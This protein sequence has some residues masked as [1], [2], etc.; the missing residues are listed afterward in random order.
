LVQFPVAI[1]SPNISV[2]NDELCGQA[3]HS[4]LSKM[5]ASRLHAAA[6]IV[7]FN[8]ATGF[9]SLTMTGSSLSCLSLA[10]VASSSAW[11]SWMVRVLSAFQNGFAAVHQCQ[12]LVECERDQPSWRAAS[13]RSPFS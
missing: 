10:S 11:P 3:A 1:A 7:F 4:V 13:S 6:S 5:A 9:F 8:S 2:C 12:A